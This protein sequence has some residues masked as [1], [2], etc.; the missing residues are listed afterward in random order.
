MFENIL[1]LKTIVILLFGFIPFTSA[2][3]YYADEGFY[4]DS[5]KVGISKKGLWI[6][7]LITSFFCAVVFI[8]IFVICINKQNKEKRKIHYIND[9]EVSNNDNTVTK[10]PEAN[11]SVSP[12]VYSQPT[13]LPYLTTYYPQLSVTQPV[14]QIDPK[15]NPGVGLIPGFTPGV[16]PSSIPIVIPG[17]AP[18]V[19]ATTTPVATVASTAPIIKASTVAPVNTV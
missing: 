2:Y 17:V 16:I 14:V 6:I 9:E 10:A 13:V 1:N 3:S 5:N 12:Q 11:E 15:T 7:L 8:T 19:T 18:A 4:D